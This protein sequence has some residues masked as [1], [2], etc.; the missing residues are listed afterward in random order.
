MESTPPPRN[1][2]LLEELQWGHGGE[3]AES[4]DGGTARTVNPD[5][6]QW[7]HGGEAAE[8]RRVGLDASD[9]IGLQWG[10]GGEAVERGDMLTSDV[11]KRMR[12]NGAAAVRPRKDMSKSKSLSNGLQWGHGGEAAESEIIP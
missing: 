5:E 12:F 9:R 6:L 11:R 7:G 3:A 2:R 4:T 8:S 10:H 1:Y